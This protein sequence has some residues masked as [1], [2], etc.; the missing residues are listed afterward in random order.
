MSQ[1]VYGA[2][3]DLPVGP[4]WRVEKEVKSVITVIAKTHHYWA[5]HMSP[6][7]QQIIANLFAAMQV[8]SPLCC[9]QP[10]SGAAMMTSTTD[11]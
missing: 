6:W 11:R 5:G 10:G 7:Q 8:E 3:L 4:T 9:N 2:L 1:S